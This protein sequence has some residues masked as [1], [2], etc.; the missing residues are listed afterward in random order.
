[1]VECGIIVSSM[2]QCLSR[3]RAKWAKPEDSFLKKNRSLILATE[4]IPGA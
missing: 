4:V 3:Q 1:M 2:V